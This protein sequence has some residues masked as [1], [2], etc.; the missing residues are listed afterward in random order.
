MVPP[1]AV[2]QSYGHGTSPQ[3]FGPDGFT[4]ISRRCQMEKI[5]I[6]VDDFEFVGELDEVT[7]GWSGPTDD[8][9]DGDWTP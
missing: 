2:G 4:H 1:F 6:A 9:F 8:T 7:M 3:G 5:E